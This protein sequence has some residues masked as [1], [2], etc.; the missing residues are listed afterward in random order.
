M[1]LPSG[2]CVPVGVAPRCR[3]GMQSGMAGE[4]PTRR[5]SIRGTDIDRR[6]L[7]LALSVSKQLYVCPSC[8]SHVEIGSEHVVVR[9]VESPEGSFHQHWHSECVRTKLLRTMNQVH[10]I[11]VRKR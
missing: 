8:R 4:M 11:G 10:R 2:V 6:R 7:E 1:D 3:C 5:F 9:I